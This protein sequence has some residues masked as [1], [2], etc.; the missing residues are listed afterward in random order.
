MVWLPGALSTSHGSFSALQAQRCCRNCGLSVRSD[1]SMVQLCFA[2]LRKKNACSAGM[3]FQ[4]P[5][6]SKALFAI[7]IILLY[8]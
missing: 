8:L 7:G 3:R 2:C 1:S 6:Q 4:H 5:L